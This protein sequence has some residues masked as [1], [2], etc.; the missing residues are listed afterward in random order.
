MDLPPKLLRIL[1][2]PEKE[3]KKG[4]IPRRLLKSFTGH[5]QGVN[6]VRW[7]RPYL[8]PNNDITSNISFILFRNGQLLAS[9]SMDHT[10]RIWDPFKAM[11]C[12]QVLKAHTGRNNL[13]S[14]FC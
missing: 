9:A 10:V 7:C 13:L 6:C 8:P 1:N 3:A 5:T 4:L 14:G 12:V 2:H 11:D